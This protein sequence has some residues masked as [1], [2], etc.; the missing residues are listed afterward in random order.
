MKSDGINGSDDQVSDE[1]TTIEARMRTHL[2]IMAN[3]KARTK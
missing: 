2:P 1:K 3:H